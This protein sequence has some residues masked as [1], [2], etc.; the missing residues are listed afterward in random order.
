MYY[1]YGVSGPSLLIE[2]TDSMIGS[3]S[4]RLASS[5]HLTCISSAEWHLNWGQNLIW[6]HNISLLVVA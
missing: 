3:G 6:R 1:V 2:S 4:M 5:T